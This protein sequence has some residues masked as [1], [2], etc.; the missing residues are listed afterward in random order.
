MTADFEEDWTNVKRPYAR[1]ALSVGLA[2]WAAVALA[3]FLQHFMEMEPCA[4]CTLQ[5]LLFIVMGALAVG[6]F[7]A[8]STPGPAKLLAGLSAVSGAA[9]VAAALWQHFVAAPGG[10]CDL[11]LADKIISS[12]QLDQLMPWMFQATA[13]CDE[14]NLPMLGVPFALWSAM[15]FVVLTLIMLIVAFSRGPMK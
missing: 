14:A 12:S 8:A 11:T 1:Y 10:S 2:A 6:A 4:W 5:R 3:L 7:L 15:L 9:G 13:M